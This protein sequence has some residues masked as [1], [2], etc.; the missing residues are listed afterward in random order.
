MAAIAVYNLN[1]AWSAVTQSRRRALLWDLD[2]QAA[3]THLIGANDAPKSMGTVA[4]LFAH[5]DD[6]SA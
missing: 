5:G 4:W 1:L 6:P 3:A 2:P